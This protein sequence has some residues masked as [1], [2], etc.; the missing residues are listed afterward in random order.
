MTSPISFTLSGAAVAVGVDPA[1]R[2]ADT[3]REDLRLTGTKIGCNAGDC[4]ACTV[5]LDGRQVCACLVATRQVGGRAVVTVEGLGRDGRLTQLQR[6]FH[7]HGAAQCGICTPGMLMAADDLLARNRKPT[8]AQVLDALGGVLCRCTGY[9][10]IVEAVLA[11]GASAETTAPPAGH[12]VGARL[13]KTDGLAKL[14]GSEKFGADA[15]PAD[16]LVRRAVRSPHHRARFSFGDFAALHQKYPGLVKILTWK[17]IPGQ[18]LYGIYPTGKDQPALAGG[19]VRHRGEAVAALVRD[20]PASV[21]IRDEGLPIEWQ[22]LPPL[23]FDDAMR[24]GAPALHDAKPDNVLVKGRVVRGDP[25]VAMAKA[26]AVA[27]GR[28]E[29]AF[30][31]HAYI[32]PEAGF[33]RRVGDGSEITACTPTPHMHRDEM[34]LIMGL[35]PDQVRIIPTA[36]GGGFGGKLDL[37]LQP[38]I[39]TAAWILQRPLRCTYTR[40]E[41]MAST[42]KRRP[43]RIDARFACHA[44]GKLLAVEF[45]GDFNTGAYASWGPTVAT[46]VPVH[47]MGPYELPE[48]NA[49]TRAIYTS[50]TPAGAFRGFGVPQAAIA[51]ESL[52]GDLPRSLA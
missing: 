10:K 14:T 17:D 29:T 1:G 36:V 3:L 12:A 41:S 15:W 27:E 50:D 42:P 22:P 24:P 4:G 39:A 25:P 31:E 6:A 23:S 34:A 20:E 43:A 44:K 35:R 21:A 51:H 38:L 5:R 33:A 2:L 40:P 18:N 32:A 8:E 30:V 45:H 46:R 48:V 49:T 26:A 47:A 16:A 9:R 37:S 13:P 11:V 7:A 52:M 19:L 28:F